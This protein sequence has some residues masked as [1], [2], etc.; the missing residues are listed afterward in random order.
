MARDY[1]RIEVQVG[2]P[3]GAPHV[4]E[5]VRSRRPP[6]EGPAECRMTYAEAREVFRVEPLAAGS[7][8]GRRT[9]G[10]W[11]AGLGPGGTR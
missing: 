5:R 9:G 8:G 3:G 11:G 4:R 6:P 1:N 7:G 2:S 10:E